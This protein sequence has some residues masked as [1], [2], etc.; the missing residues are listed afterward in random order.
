MKVE[1]EKEFENAKSVAA[2]LYCDVAVFE[3]TEMTQ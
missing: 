1:L 2:G 3:K